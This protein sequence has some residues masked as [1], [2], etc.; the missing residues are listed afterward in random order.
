[1]SDKT[2]DIPRWAADFDAVVWERI[3]ELL[4][5]GWDTQDI[6]REL[7]LPN[8]KLRSLQELAKAYGPRRRLNHFQKFKD[9]V[10]KGVADIGPEFQKALALIAAN[11]AS[12]N[13]KES[14]QER[15][16]Q[17]MI[18]VAKLVTRMAGIELEAETER[19]EAA[20]ETGT[21]KEL[22]ADAIQ[23]IKEIYGVGGGH[24]GG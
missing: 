13:V 8:S 17:L 20:N 23:K 3:N 9:A 7:S 11:A 19:K 18:D 5:D 1:M 22:S 4:A 2:N 15:A 24:H 10:M 16:M 6:V 21:G 12:P 14:T